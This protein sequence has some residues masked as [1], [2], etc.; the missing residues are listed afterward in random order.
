MHRVSPCQQ[1]QEDGALET[2]PNPIVEGY[3]RMTQC[4]S[5]SNWSV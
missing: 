3:A 4:A 5:S 2:N 1:V